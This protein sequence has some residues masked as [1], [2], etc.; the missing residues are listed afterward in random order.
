MEATRAVD[1]AQ[2]KGTIRLVTYVYRPVKND[3]HEVAVFSHGSTGGLATLAQG[4]GWEQC[5]AAGR[6]AVP[7]HAR[8]HR[9]R[10]DEAGTRRVHRHLRRRMWT[11]QADALLKTVETT[12]R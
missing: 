10:A 6:R 2:D 1:D 5:P 4:A 7:G 12:K 9:G 8:V 3:R 11:T